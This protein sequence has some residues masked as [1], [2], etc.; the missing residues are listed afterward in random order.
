MKRVQKWLASLLAV[1]MVIG[2]VPLSALAAERDN[3]VRVIVENTTF[4]PETA[5]EVGGTW[6]ESFWH[7]TLVDTWVGINDESTMMS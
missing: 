2:M 5:D 3:Q 7:G 6:N 1:I 4:T